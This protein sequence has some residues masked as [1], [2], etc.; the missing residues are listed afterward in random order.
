M[1]IPESQLEIWA[2]QGSITQSSNTYKIIKNALESPRAPYAGKSFRVFLQG[3]YANDTNIY[4][5]SDVDVVIQLDDCFHHN[6]SALP[7]EEQAEFNKTYSNSTYRFLNF[8]NDVEAALRIAFGNDVK[9]RNKAIEVAAGGGRRKVDVIV[10]TQFRRYQRFESEWNSKFDEGIC[11]FNEKGTM[12]VNFPKAHSANLTAKHQQSYEWLKPMVRVVKNMRETLI[13]LHWLDNADAPSYFL[14][15]LLYN[16]P[17]EKFG[18]SLGS[19]FA[20]SFDW[21]WDA[22]RTSFVCA[23]E[24]YKLL[25]PNTCEC[26]DSASCDK[27][28]VQAVK[29]WKNW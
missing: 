13:E 21:I 5:E 19:S 12:I 11:F 16:V 27:F 10:A 17:N 26:W 24:R 25:F 14:E 9:R 7:A 23:N 20:K 28:V 8:K 18:G 2:K 29:L 15:G 22:D 3:S 4:S 1:S 6:V